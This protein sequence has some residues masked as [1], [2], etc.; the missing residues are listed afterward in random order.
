MNELSDEL[1]LAVFRHLTPKDLLRLSRVNKRWA[2]VSGDAQLWPCIDLSSNGASQFDANCDPNRVLDTLARRRIDPTRIESLDLSRS[3]VSLEGIETIMNHYVNVETLSLSW[4]RNR[5]SDVSQ[6]V[7]WTLRRLRVLHL[8][9]CASFSDDDAETIADCCRE[10]IELDLSYCDQKFTDL[11]LGHVAGKCLLLEQL[12]LHSCARLTDKGVTEVGLH[13][14]RLTHLNLNSL[15]FVSDRCIA[16]VAQNNPRLQ[17]IHLDFS[18]NVTDVGVI[19]LATNCT[20]LREMH[21][22]LCFALSDRSLTSIAHHC[23]LLEV[24]VLFG[25]DGVT[26]VGVELVARHC[27]RLRLLEVS[28]S[29]SVTD[30]SLLCISECLPCVEHLRFRQCHRIT[31]VGVLAIVEKCSALITFLVQECSSIGKGLHHAEIVPGDSVV[32]NV[33]SGLQLLH[34][35][36]CQYLNDFCV[37]S[38]ARRC[39]NLLELDVSLCSMLSDDGIAAVSKHCSRLIT[40]KL[41]WCVCLTDKILYSL[42]KNCQ[43]LRLLTLGSCDSISDAAVNQLKITLTKCTVSG[44]R[45]CRKGA[46]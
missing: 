35:S 16:T 14:T 22:R 39:P 11:G 20:Q 38:I 42:G 15:E 33:S 30:R 12:S 41:H 13:L 46:E 19:P 43:E 3:S 8:A 31:H 23:P 1:L 45:R 26:D 5:L 9:G 25:S 36:G 44:I 27:S 21:L 34:L 7:T 17:S 28:A 24:L 6:G 37:S 10:L 29:R 40:L 32:A 4:C 2:R 18:E